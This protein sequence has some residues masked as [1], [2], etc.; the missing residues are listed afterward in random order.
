MQKV[1]EKREEPKENQIAKAKKKPKNTKRM[2]RRKNAKLYPIYKMFSWDLLCFYS[3]QFLFYTITKEITTSQVLIS[4]AIYL[5]A[6]IVME[7]PAVTFSDLYGYRKSLIVGNALVFISMLSL[8][9]LPGFGAIVVLNIISALGYDMK[10]IAE[11]NLLYDSVSTKGG[12]GLYSRIEERGSSWYYYLDGILCL[13][14]GYLFV[15]N[16]YI[17]IYI[18]TL[19]TLISTIMSFK[20]QDIHKKQKKEKENIFTV[21]KEYAVDL[22]TSVKFIIKSNR[23]RAYIIFGTIFYG[24][25]KVIGTYKSEALLAQGVSEQE[26]STIFAILTLL[27]GVPTAFSSKFHKKFKNKTLTV[28]SLIYVITCIVIAIAINAFTNN[29]AIPIIILGCAIFKIIESLWYVLEYKYLKNFTT[30]NIRSKIS[31]TFDTI[32]CL[33]ASIMSLLGAWILDV[34][35]I[36]NAFVIVS[37][38][39]L[40]MIVLILDYMKGRIGLKPSQYKKEDIDFE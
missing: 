27:S 9:F 29:I 14:A 26:Y 6:K 2:I 16:N 3:I 36:N 21:V 12:E 11:T 31:F 32:S 19:F 7:I 34:T 25:I 39:F 35:T 38:V 24:I 30:E 33:G 4:N 8:I 15:V 20:F 18:C 28:M 22:K 17:P 13:I 23:L 37:L 10:A 1:K 5:I 40:I